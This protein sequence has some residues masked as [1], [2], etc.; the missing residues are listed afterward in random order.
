VTTFHWTDQII[1]YRQSKVVTR[2]VYLSY[3]ELVLFG[4]LDNLLHEV[5]KILHYNSV[6]IG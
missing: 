2:I 3:P 6:N 1:L 5:P 4:W